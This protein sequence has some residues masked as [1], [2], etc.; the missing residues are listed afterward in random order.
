MCGIAGWYR[1]RGRPVSR[2]LIKA[3]CDEIRHRGPDDSG[4]IADGDFGFGMRRLS[5]V[6]IVGGHQPMSTADGRF[7]IVFNGEIYNH[8]EV[9]EEVGDRYAF[10]T[11]CDTETILA[12]FKLWGNDAWRRLE[13]MLDIAR[14]GQELQTSDAGPRSSRDQAALFF[15]TEW[16][17]CLRIRA[18]GHPTLPRS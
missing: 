15:G 18:Q 5:I 4:I 10:T 2:A 9:R 17:T 13:G 3:Q 7:Q 6:D 16:R 11:H 14:L 12:A 8:L 1:Q